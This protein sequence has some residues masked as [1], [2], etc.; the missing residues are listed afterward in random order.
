MPHIVLI[1]HRTL[2]FYK[3]GF[4]L[5]ACTHKNVTFEIGYVLWEGVK[6]KKNSGKKMKNV[7]YVMKRILSDMGHLASLEQ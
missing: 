6:K 7:L 5:A 3:N 1:F 2:M 4:E